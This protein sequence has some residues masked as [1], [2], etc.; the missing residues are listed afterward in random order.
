[1]RFAKRP[2]KGGLLRQPLQAAFC[3]ERWRLSHLRFRYAVLA[4]YT[5]ATK[6]G[7]PKEGHRGSRRKQRESDD[8]IVLPRESDDT[9]KRCRLDRCE[10]IVC[11]RQL[12]EDEPGD[13]SLAYGREGR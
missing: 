2:S 11:E 13:Q 7:E 5:G 6:R 3:Y 9:W 12:G 10:V 8:I 4:G 1:M